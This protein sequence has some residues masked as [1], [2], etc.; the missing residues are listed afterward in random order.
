MSEFEARDRARQVNIAGDNTGEIIVTDGS[1]TTR[2]RP[3]VTAT[4]RHDVGALVGREEE[5]NQILTT[6]RG[7]GPSIHT[8]DGMAGVGKTAL[9]I[10]AAH[11]LRAGFPDGQYFV[12]L[13]GHTPG[14]APTEP[15]EV[16]TGLLIGLGVDP[17]FVPETLTGQRDM[18]RDRTADKQVLLVLD[19]ARDHIQIE[20]L[21]PSGSGCATLVTSR[22]RLIALDGAQPLALRV[23]EEDAATELFTS[24]AQRMTVTV[25]ERA[26]A[27]KIVRLCGYLPLATVL[28]AGRLAHH[29]AWSLDQLSG[30]FSAAADR[31]AELDTGD[32]TVRAAFTMSYQNLPPRLQRVFRRLGLHPGPEVDAYATAALTDLPVQVARRE[33]ERLYT[34]HLLDETG[35]GRYRLHDL[36]RD[37]ARTLATVGD[38][39]ADN[40]RSMDR[41]LDYFHDTAAAA[42]WHLTRRFRSSSG[43][44]VRSAAS[45]RPIFTDQ[46]EALAWLRTERRNLL[47]CVEYVTDARPTRM[48]ELTGLVAGLLERDGM[49]S[50]AADLYQRAAEASAR[51][52][53]HIGRAAAL[54]NLHALHEQSR[55]HHTFDAPIQQARTALR[56]EI[57]HRLDEAS[58]LNTL[59]FVRSQTGRFA[60]AE[61]LQQQALA[62]F[63]EIGDSFGEAYAL[64][65]LAH[66]RLWTAA[67]GKA[68]LLQRRAL[69]IFQKIGDR[70]GEA[71]ILTILAFVRTYTGEFDDAV[72]L[73]RQTLEIYRELG[74]RIS[75]ANPLV[76]IGMIRVWTGAYGEAD[77]ILHQAVTTSHEIGNRF[78]EANALQWLG[79][80]RQHTGDHGEAE[81]LLRRS[82]SIQR[83]INHR[84]G[85]AFALTALGAL[86]VQAGR[87]HDA[88]E[89]LRRALEIS[90]EIGDR[91]GEADTLTEI[92][93]LLLQIGAPGRAAWIFTAALDIARDIGILHQQ[94]R[95]LDGLAHCHANLGDS[96]SS[97]VNLREAIE[98]YRRLGTPEA[99][100]ATTYLTSLGPL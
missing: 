56:G 94:A 36:L 21:L 89:H 80:L 70:F 88:G 16:L 49:W 2:P 8:I 93:N 59:G 25:A 86:Q 83:E 99:V 87:H 74:D 33:L 13:H 31:L 52:G 6:R 35:P 72:T 39:V 79:S 42:D 75:E 14:K 7:S 81:D 34:D 69:A 45:G 11:E 18:W 4:L 5:L 10:R 22:R 67:Y 37:Y 92:G 30:E 53:D 19:D 63:R 15:A 38:I 65:G 23:L 28:L 76:G 27:A 95:A 100:A 97:V 32:R 96:R 51:L 62:I 20:P 48:V 44:N 98:I 58:A 55:Q 73:H 85:E 47:A 68:V 24:L 77:D 57:G 9:A 29:P 41:L 78:G 84:I 60:E 3:V 71:N 50:Q 66:I 90:R 82:L 64:L 12:E 43:I 61:D 91:R 17:R 26:A 40:D 54:T 1:G 46:Q